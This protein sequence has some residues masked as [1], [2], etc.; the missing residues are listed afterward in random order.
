M[1]T[2]R[3]LPGKLSYVSE[4][5]DEKDSPRGRLY[6][7][8]GLWEGE[9][10]LEQSVIDPL[11][12]CLDCRACESACPSGVPY[13]ELREKKRAELFGKKHAS[14]FERGVFLRNLLLK[15]LFRY[16]SMMTAASRIL[17]IYAPQ[18]SPKFITKTFIGK[19]LP[20]SF[21]FQQHLFPIF[22]ENRSNANMPIK[23]FH[24]FFPKKNTTHYT[25]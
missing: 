22:Q 7:M 11:S 3:T 5:E 4:L 20:K 8:R 1:C 24:L 19:L 17:K 16:T 18:D 9:L 6:L 15:G 23:S 10:E 14:K 2:L 13:G 25:K 12:R 21:V